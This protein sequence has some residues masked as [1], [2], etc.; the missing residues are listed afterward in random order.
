VKRA[1]YRVQTILLVVAAIVVALVFSLAGIFSAGSHSSAG[2]AAQGASAGSTAGMPLARLAELSMD[3]TPQQI[4]VWAQQPVSN[5]IS[6][7]LSDPR[8]LS[9]VFEW[10]AS[11]TSYI[12]R[13]MLS[14]R[15]AIPDSDPLLRQ[16]SA[17]F[18][19]RLRKKPDGSHSYQS[20]GAWFD[21]DSDVSIR[22]WPSDNPSNPN[23]HHQMVALWQLL[24]PLIL[25]QPLHLDA[26]TKR[27]W[28][29][30]GYPVSALANVSP[31]LDIDTS[32]AGLLALFPGVS[33]A[34]GIGLTYTVPLDDPWF[35]VA[36]LTFA[37]EKGGKL[38]TVSLRP[39][40]GD[41]A[42]NQKELSVCLASGLGKPV[43][44]E[45]DHLAGTV[46]YAWDAH[47]PKA[48]L[49]VNT[50]YVWLDLKQSA[51]VGVAPITLAGVA[52]ALAGC[53]R[54]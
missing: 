39:P 27:D 20:N 8:Y 42:L 15:S 51:G 19:A 31:A 43:E 5:R 11:D 36:E 2:A 45:A 33:W 12:G 14:T 52:G 34:T 47:W 29:G 49:D 6:V 4:A 48:S 24:E 9:V 37:N 50:S 32:R 18:G 30:L 25:N 35:S 40:V 41:D 23:W 26:N 1:A 13:V 3:R 28:L 46:T 10:P 17:V 16:A 38:S 7:P 22:V 54:R 53:S 21:V 44:H